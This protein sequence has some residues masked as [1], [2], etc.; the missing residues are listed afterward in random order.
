MN[1]A[2]VLIIYS[3]KQ[4]IK[5]QYTLGMTMTNLFKLTAVSSLVLASMT[6]PMHA[7]A[8]DTIA[9]TEQNYN[10]AAAAKYMG[11]WDKHGADKGIVHLPALVPAGNKAPVVR[12]NQ[13]SLY[14]A[15][16]AHA[17][18]DGFIHVTI[19]EFE[20]E[21]GTQDVYTSVHILDENSASPM[22]KVG[23]GEYSVKIDTDFA[24]IIFRAGVEDKSDVTNALAAQSR[25]HVDYSGTEEFSPQGYVAPN[26]DVA[27]RD[28]M[29][30]KLKQE[31][32]EA[33]EDFFYVESS[34][35][36]DANNGRQMR[37]NAQGWGG[38][39]IEVGVSNIYRNTKQFE[40]SVCQTTTFQEPD[41]KYFTSI[42][43]YDAAGY[44]L[45]TERFSINSYEWDKNA[46]GSVTI[47]F[48]CGD[49]APNNLE[50]NGEDF[51]YTVRNYG[52]S[53]DVEYDLFGGRELKYLAG[54]AVNPDH[55]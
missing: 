54:G 36:A 7:V 31:F 42:T 23:P 14:S 55:K 22:Y 45:D 12:M 51:N 37:S 28:A 53:H 29:T 52:A 11:N 34:D 13:D 4:M 25:F 46:D 19:D 35:A 1:H 41:N 10:Q 33:G 9:V 43:L 21:S 48:G 15:A 20:N 38:M 17:D 39:P 30:K 2:Q 8:T 3:N 5:P 50:T 49:G 24:F 47:S 44:M 18:K 16:I 32:L 27:Q 40:G 6:L 26:Y